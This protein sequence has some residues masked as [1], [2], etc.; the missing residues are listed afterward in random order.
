MICLIYFSVA[1]FN[2][3][4]KF[5]CLNLDIDDLMLIDL[6]ISSI[7]KLLFRSFDRHSDETVAHS[8][9]LLD[10]NNFSKTIIVHVSE[11]LMSSASELYELLR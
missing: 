6:H 2:D 9:L 5:R 7:T 3:K 8:E 11:S 4:I 10:I 1:Q